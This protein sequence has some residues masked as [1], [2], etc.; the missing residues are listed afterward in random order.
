MRIYTLFLS[1]N[2]IGQINMLSDIRYC[3]S[4]FNEVVFF[5]F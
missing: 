5:D 3:K 2:R 4:S 1:I